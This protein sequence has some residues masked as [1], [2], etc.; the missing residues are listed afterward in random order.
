MDECADVLTAEFARGLRQNAFIIIKLLLQ[1]PVFD[2]LFLISVYLLA[3]SFPGLPSSFIIFCSRCL[4]RPRW[5]NIMP[6]HA[7]LKDRRIANLLTYIRSNFGN[8]APAIT[9]EEV[10]AVREKL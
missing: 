5:R 8:K 4:A 9:A 1:D 7:N 10:K 6:G 2:L 3:P